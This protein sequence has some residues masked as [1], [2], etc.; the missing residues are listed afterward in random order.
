[1]KRLIAVLGTCVVLFMTSGA[2]A[3]DISVAENW[4]AAWNS[5]DVNRVLGVFTSDVLYEDVP[6]GVVNQ[7]AEELG[8]FQGQHAAE[9][10]QG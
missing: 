3:D 2:T 10:P 7:G 6:L 5:H 4:I 1:M 9:S 8:M